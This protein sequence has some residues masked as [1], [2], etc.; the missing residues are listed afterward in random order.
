MTARYT[1]ERDGREALLTAHRAI[2]SGSRHANTFAAIRECLQAGVPR[3]EI[4]IHSLAGPDYIV[5]HN[6]HL[7]QGTTGSG[8]IGGLTPTAV[9]ACRFTHDPDDRPPLLSEVVDL[10][11]QAPG[12]QIQLDLKDWRAMSEDR[13]RTLLGLIAPVHGHVIISMGQDWNLRRLHRAD[14]EL[15]LGFDPGH[16]IDYAIESDV[17]FLPRAMGAYGYRDDHPMAIGKTE[18]VTRYLADRMEML[19]CQAPFAQEFFLDYH[20]ILQMTGDG[21]DVAAWLHRRDIDVTA[22]T[23]DYRG[24]DSLA[25]LDRLIA[26]GV[27]R[28]TTNTIPAWLAA[29]VGWPLTTDY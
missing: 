23:P 29:T 10:A 8:S 22:W 12:T 1:I 7:E 14:P 11:R 28:I 25:V 5:F 9:R 20:L 13:I 2:L 16:Y 19:V 17:F 3:I 4:D 21:F 15:A 6:H 27:D 24:P 18:D 26:A